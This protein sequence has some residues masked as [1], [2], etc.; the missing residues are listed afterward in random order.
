MILDRVA[1]TC[2]KRPKIVLVAVLITTLILVSG[3]LKIEKETDMMAFLPE[4][5]ESV[6]TTLEFVEEFGG[7]K[8]ETVLVKGDVTSPQA[9]KEIQS[10]EEEIRAIPNFALEVRSYIDILKANNVPE[11]MMPMAVRSPEAKE[12][13]T[14]MLTGDGKAALIRVRVNPEYKGDMHEYIDILE[15]ERSLDI[16]YTGEL[17]QAE[18]MMGT[19]DRDNMILLPAA[20]LMIVAVLFLAYRRI[21]DV[22][23]PFLVIGIAVT[24]VLG[25]MGYMGISFSSMFVGV[26]PLLLG[27]AIAYAVH[28]LNRYYEERNKGKKVEESAVVSVK[29]VGVAVLLTAVTTAFGFGSFLISDLPPIR[30]F[31]MLLVLG[32][33]FSFLLVVTLMPSLLVLRDKGAKPKKRKKAS[34]VDYFLDRVSLLALH[35]RKVVLSIAAVATVLCIAVLPGISTSTNYNDMIPEDAETITAQEE[36]TDLLGM[37]GEPLVILVEGNL[38]EKYQE[39]LSL[40]SELKKIEFTSEEGEPIVLEVSS[41]ADILATTQGSIEV[42]M[43]DQ[44][45]AGMLNQTMVLGKEDPDYLKKGLVLLY[46]NAKSDEDARKI[47]EE[48]RD[49]LKSYTSL[50]YRVGGGPALIADIMGGMKSTQLKTTLLALVL[51]LIVVSL[52]FK[53]LPLGIFSIIPLAMTISWEFGVLK[54]ASWNLDLFTV[55]VSALIIGIGI[56]FSI[57]VIHRYREEFEKT[58]DTEKSVE[59]TVLSVGKALMC[60]TATTAGAFFVLSFSSMPMMTRF[61]L[62]VSIVILLAFLAALLV[63]PSILVF[64]YKGR[65]RS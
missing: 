37:K 60:A 33:L 54:I 48:V 29:T 38:I 30:E 5:K 21:S 65:T 14:G 19:M 35:H 27:I 11:A 9:I 58:K 7:Q 49:I 42:A 18:E 8:C 34:G 13:F 57:H 43:K 10:L 3:L 2:E 62:L 50:E 64:Y 51:S 47:T 16:S 46:V 36:I 26:A 20:V 59:N 41:Y 23:L 6:K 12:G 56:D 53:S 39:V 40:E 61:G 15:K 31:G 17:T 45:A 22:L 55:M 44:R 24:W 4:D 28:M 63:L 32:I 52:L 1:E 25:V